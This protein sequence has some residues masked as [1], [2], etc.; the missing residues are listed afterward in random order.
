M[1]VKLLTVE[2]AV[3][4][5]SGICS[6]RHKGTEQVSV[7]SDALATIGE[8]PQSPLNL[9]TIWGHA[10][11][12][13]SYIM[14]LLARRGKEVIFPVLRVFKACTVGADMSKATVGLA[15]FTQSSDAAGEEELGEGG[16]PE[17][18]FVD[19]EGQGDRHQ[20]HDILLATPLLLLS[21]V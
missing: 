7:T 20:S 12:G 14:N 2:G 16:S 19:V 18:G 3:S 9:V 17:I 1:S 10:R 8:L 21:K 15:P 13:K 4:M 11:T 6:E 5:T